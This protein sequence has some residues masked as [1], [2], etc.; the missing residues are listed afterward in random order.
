LNLL[1]IKQRQLSAEQ[2]S[3]PKQSLT[4]HSVTRMMLQTM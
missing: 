2:K 1:S 4:L 3:K